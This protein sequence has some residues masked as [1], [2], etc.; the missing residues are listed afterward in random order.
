MYYNLHYKFTIY[1]ILSYHW[2]YMIYVG[3]SKY[4]V[5]G[6]AGCTICKI[7]SA[8]VIQDLN[9]EGCFY[10]LPTCPLT[11]S[12][13]T[14]THVNCLVDN[15]HSFCVQAGCFEGRPAQA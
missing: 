9:T 8:S 11:T 2:Q 13:D 3:I 7:L 10:Y 1:I 6:W 15:V 4:V 14:L 12:P 5:G